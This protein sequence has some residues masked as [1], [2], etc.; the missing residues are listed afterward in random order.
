MPY[1]TAPIHV[2]ALG[3]LQ[4]RRGPI[5]V[6]LG[7]PKQ[8]ALFAS[9]ALNAGRVVATDPLIHALWGMDSP[10]SARH[11]VHTYVARL[12]Q[13]L[14]P[15]TP[16]RGRI[17]VI[18]STTN[19]YR[20]LVEHDHI[21][22]H[23]FA[24]RREQAARQLAAGRRRRALELLGEAVRLWRD[25]FLRDL[26][27]LLPHSS[28][29]EQMRQ[30]WAAAVLEYVTLGL[31]LGEASVVWPLA[32]QLA[33][34]EPMH[35]QAQANYLLALDHTGRRAAAIAHF[36][37]VRERL[38]S[39]LGVA[40]GPELISAY[41]HLQGGRSQPQPAPASTT[42]APPATRAP[43][44]GPGP[45]LGELIQRDDELAA[46]SQRLSTH[47]L[48]TVA[49]PPGCGKSE[50]ALHAAARLRET[51]AGG[52]L[53]LDCADLTGA[54][55]L[56]RRL[57]RLLGGDEPEEPAA[58]AGGQEL[59]IVLDNIEHLVDEVAVEVDEIVRACWH[60]YVIVTSREPL[61]LPDEAVIRV[62]TL[63]VPPA[64][65]SSWPDGY[66]S[67]KL[68]VRRVV[69]VRPDFRLGPDNA[70]L[71]ATICRRLDG[72]PLAVEMAAAC[73]ATDSLEGLVERLDGPLREVA[74]LRRGRPAHHRSL[75]SMLHR[76]VD[77]L[78]EFERWCFRQLGTL[79]PCFGL[80]DAYRACSSPGVHTGDVALALTRLVDK[81]L[82]QLGDPADCP[83]YR[84]LSL[85]HRFAG[86]LS[87]DRV[88]GATA[89]PTGRQ[90]VHDR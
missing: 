49:G 22:V 41:Q 24:G 12:R 71:V 62:P 36:H 8:R 20:L 17:N 47:R 57:V 88:T 67:I 77:C 82:V 6:D 75:W 69:Q 42:S 44:R 15:E 83:G 59:L 26:A 56:R 60:V 34:S 86:E 3:Q 21:D 5:L 89:P 61:G 68:F 33:M 79:P 1:R 73:L 58:A 80:P 10:F 16:R 50:L 25:P 43:W 40:P 35:E 7:P 23:R 53:V 48:V 84:M 38:R 54:D 9:L 28:A 65:G 13:V 27:D 74:A 4:V 45:G 30:E 39:E 76:S 55:S 85:I 19:G 2:N 52:V 51:V 14:E 64:A 70:D 63:P 66:A 31:D 90:L 78:T 11:L 87:T 46:I 32:E 29:V 18:G 37:E 81:S 72:L